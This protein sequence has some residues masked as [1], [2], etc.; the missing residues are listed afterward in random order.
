MVWY[1]SIFIS[2]SGY[3]VGQCNFPESYKL[4]VP[5]C[6]KHQCLFF[7]NINPVLPPSLYSEDSFT[8]PS[9]GPYVYWISIPLLGNSPYSQTNHLIWRLVWLTDVN[10]SFNKIIFSVIGVNRCFR[11]KVCW[12]YVKTTWSSMN[13]LINLTINLYL[14]V[15]GLVC[16]FG[17]DFTLHFSSEYCVSC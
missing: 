3:T 15:D 11:L 8:N 7:Q 9:N 14:L 1:I 17:D 16:S 10:L 2:I 6:G 4:I 12:S 13:D 5:S